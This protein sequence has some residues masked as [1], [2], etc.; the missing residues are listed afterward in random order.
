M[1]RVLHIL[2][3]RPNYMKIAPVFEAL[4]RRGGFEQ[5][6]VNTGQHYDEA[7]AGI[8]LREFQL[9]APDV[10]LGVG[11]GTHA[12]QTA[13]VMVGV[14]EV[15]LD[16]RPDLIHVVGDVNSTMAAA[17]VGAKLRVPVAH[18]EAGL[19]SFDPDMPEEINR[20]VTD[21]V[22]D[23]LLTPSADA[24]RNLAAEGIPPAKIRRVGNVMIDTLK[25]FLPLATIDRAT[26]LSGAWRFPDHA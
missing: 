25:R 26:L 13:K 15:C 12:V 24:D 21:R 20:V 14:E 16:R 2:G 1:K 17:L 9:P 4:R 6:L 3:A 8:F 7:M 5:L 23:L 22:A 11:S 10:D 19:R 18:V